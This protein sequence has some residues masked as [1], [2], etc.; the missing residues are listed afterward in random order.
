MGACVLPRILLKQL[1]QVVRMDMHAPNKFLSCPDA[2]GGIVIDVGSFLFKQIK[3]MMGVGKAFR[4]L[5]GFRIG[6]SRG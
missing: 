3:K 2:D 6:S 5:I 4:Y 1:I